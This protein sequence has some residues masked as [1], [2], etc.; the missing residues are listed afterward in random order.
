MNCRLVPCFFLVCVAGAITPPAPKVSAADAEVVVGG[1]LAEEGGAWDP[2]TSPLQR[3]FGIDFNRNGQMFVVELEGGR[4]HRLDPDGTLTTVAGDGSKS[5]RGDGGP[6]SGATFNGMHNCAVT[7]N[8][9]LYIADSWNHC[10][11]RVDAATGIITTMAGTGKPGFSGD[12]GPARKAAFDFIMCITLNHTSDVLHVADL[13][14]RRVRA[15]ELKTGL[16]QTIA[17][18]G[19]KGV[20]AD[21]AMA[22][23]APL[24]DPRAV[25]ADSKGNVYVL[26]RSGNALRVIHT[27]GTIHTVA[28]DGQRGF[29]DGP[30]LQAQFG[31]PKHICVDDRD[32]VYI[33]DDAN[34]AIRRFDPVAKTVTTVLGRGHGDDRIQLLM[35]HGVCWQD[36][37]LYVLD[38]SHNRILRIR[39]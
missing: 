7:P 39:P 35:P 26:E 38:T 37:L 17:G 19:G 14:N 30:A 16:V 23:E 5:Y 12:G 10:I 28:G 13:K 4:V 1:L 3:P 22:T 15:V 8:G 34:K 20:P 36:N 31:S 24:V 25:A 29:R 6:F 11:R 21:G 27:D 9:D 32:N 18:N 33:A 2:A